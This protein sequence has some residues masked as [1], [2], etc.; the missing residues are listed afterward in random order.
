M[1]M[2]PIIP[3]DT[4]FPCEM[5]KTY[6]T[7]PFQEE[8]TIPVMQGE[9]KLAKD[10]H[11]IKEDTLRV[12]KVSV[13]SA[14]TVTYKIDENGILQCSAAVTTDPNNPVVIEVD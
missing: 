5:T 7:R 9:A 6:Y 3:K 2:D 13:A 8:A 1:L 14:V 4:K 10:C 12:P 11:L